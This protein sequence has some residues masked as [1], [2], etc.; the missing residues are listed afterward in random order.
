MNKEEYNKLYNQ[1][2]TQE[3]FPVQ[4]FYGQIKD[5]IKLHKALQEPHVDGVFLRGPKMNLE[6]GLAVLTFVAE[7][8]KTLE[9]KKEAEEFRQYWEQNFEGIYKKVYNL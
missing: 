6:G 8:E 2:K 1:I 5:A 3:G 7:N 9:I 4:G